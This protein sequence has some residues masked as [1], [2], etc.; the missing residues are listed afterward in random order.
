MPPP[1]DS[2]HLLI[3]YVSDTLLCLYV[4]YLYVFTTSLYLLYLLFALY[5][6]LLCLILTTKCVLLPFHREEREML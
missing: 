5:Y 2:C 4:C 1:T 6:I 3:S